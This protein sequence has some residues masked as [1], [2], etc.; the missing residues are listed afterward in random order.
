MGEPVAD[1]RRRWSARAA[2]ELSVDKITTV[3]A[4]AKRRAA[5]AARRNAD[6]RRCGAVFIRRRTAALWRSDDGAT[7]RDCSILSASIFPE[8]P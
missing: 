8:P 5:P 2:P 1:G 7:P 3:Q 6:A 4:R